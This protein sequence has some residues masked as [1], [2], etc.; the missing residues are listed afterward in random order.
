MTYLWWNK[1]TM[2]WSWKNQLFT[3]ENDLRFETTTARSWFTLNSCRWT[4]DVV[5]DEKM[6]NNMTLFCID[7]LDQ[8]K[9]I[10]VDIGHFHLRCTTCLYWAIVDWLYRHRLV[11]S[12]TRMNLT[13]QQSQKTK[14]MLKIMYDFILWA[15]KVVWS[16]RRNGRAFQPTATVYIHMDREEENVSV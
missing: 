11:R 13:Y 1:D 14:V 12:L 16:G 5:F 7:I 2:N 6:R 3:F 8:I 4:I 10:Q 9:S 15:E